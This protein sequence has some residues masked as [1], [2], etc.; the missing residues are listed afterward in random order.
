M[1]FTQPDSSL[2]EKSL[3]PSKPTILLEDSSFYL[4]REFSRL[5][6]NSRISKAAHYKTIHPL[7][8]LAFADSSNPDEFFMVHIDGLI[9]ALNADIND[10]DP[11]G[12][13]VQ[14][15]LDVVGDKVKNAVTEEYNYFAN[16]VLLAPPRQS[17][18]AL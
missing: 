16:K 4:N 3:A 18:K 12:K 15:Q 6:F 10:C 2:P 13:T 9:Q 5:E 11:N 7:K 1:T 8:K 17:E 14:G